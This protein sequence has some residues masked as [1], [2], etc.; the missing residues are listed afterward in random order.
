MKKIIVISL[1]SKTSLK[2]KQQLEAIFKDAII[3]ENYSIMQG[4]PVNISYD[5]AL[6]TSDWLR[7][8]VYKQISEAQK[9]IIAK[10]TID[11][12]EVLPIIDLSE[13]TEV[14][15]VN[16]DRK[17]AEEMIEQLQSIGINH[18]KYHKYYPGIESDIS[19]DIAITPGEP[20]I[21][22]KHVRKIIDIGDRLLDTSTLF[23]IADKC[24]VLYEK[25]EIILK[26]YAKY[27]VDISKKYK[28]KSKQAIYHRN[29][30][31]TIVQNTDEG[32]IYLNT[33][34]NITAYNSEANRILSSNL[35]GKNI[36]EILNEEF[37]LA[38]E[39]KNNIQIINE[40][41]VIISSVPVKNEEKTIG[42][43]IKLH[44]AEEIREKEHEIRRKTRKH[45]HFSRYTFDDIKTRSVQIKNIINLAKKVSKRS[46]TVLIQ[47]E[48]GTGKEYFAHAIHN[49]SDRNNGPFVPVNFA[50]I[51]ENLLESELFGYVGGAFTGAS[52]NGKTGLFE[53]AHKGTIFLDEIGD[54]PI[55]MQTRLLRVL[56]ER[57]I[58]RVGSSKIIPIDVRII[59]ATN[60]NLKNEVKEGRFR[61]DLFYRLNVVP[62]NII[63]LRERKCDIELLMLHYINLN[64]T[65]KISLISDFFSKDALSIL[66]QYDWPGN[67]RELVNAIEYFVAV[68]EPGKQISIGDI[69]NSFMIFQSSKDDKYYNEAAA[70]KN[71]SIN[72]KMLQ[73]YISDYKAG[74]ISNKKYEIDCLGWILEKIYEHNGIGRRKLREWAINEGIE[75][76]EGKIRIHLRV[77]EDLGLISTNVG[78]LGNTINE[79]GMRIIKGQ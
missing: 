10:R 13:N 19:A 18:I 34:G 15:A 75:L 70:G 24:G 71:V 33:E 26:Q 7:E 38:A 42:T 63:P 61:E 41:E 28:Q 6:V 78:A 60:K 76:G 67:I 14:M 36:E 47:G 56:Q 57:E 49:Y 27:F 69:P 65:H 54:M 8:S 64:L 66:M 37:G 73:D 52:K 48:S 29:M 74:R 11:Y 40:K 12:K 32:I 62:L 31:E 2:I 17:S 59:A 79:N 20:E 53:D 58:K 50:A 21:V 72:M 43:I 23:E 30:F 5:Y 35:E 22:P 39:I 55:N 46:S 25:K 77:L 9:I 1:Q 51:P 3:A 16:L 44:E 68:K 4:I 45:E